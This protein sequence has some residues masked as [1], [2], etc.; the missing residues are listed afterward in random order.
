MYKT[1]NLSIL[2]S[3]EYSI[4]GDGDVAKQTARKAFDLSLTIPL[5]PAAFDQL[6][7]RLEKFVDINYVFHDLVLRER[8]ITIQTGGL[9]T[10]NYSY[11]F[12]SVSN[13]DG[14]TLSLE[15]VLPQYYDH[16]ES[17]KYQNTDCGYFNSSIPNTEDNVPFYGENYENSSMSDYS[18]P[19]NENYWGDY[20]AS[21]LNQRMANV[22]HSVIEIGGTHVEPFAVDKISLR[23]TY[24]WLEPRKIGEFTPH[25]RILSSVE[26]SATFS[27]FDKYLVEVLDQTQNQETINITLGNSDGELSCQ[28][29]VLSGVYSQVEQEKTA[30]EIPT[31]TLQLLNKIT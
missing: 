25:K 6:T 31:A 21:P 26:E 16:P 7:P 1:I 28:P 27:A 10:A 15:N 20:V 11:S 4:R 8:S 30:D 19:S 24:N 18:S 13:R 3:L 22:S 2:T 23:Q 12:E 17:G 9:F 14:E 5:T 29:L